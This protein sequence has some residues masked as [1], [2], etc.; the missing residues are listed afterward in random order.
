[1]ERKGGQKRREERRGEQRR[2]EGRRIGIS[3]LTAAPT[4]R[5]SSRGCS[6]NRKAG[7]W[8]H[9]FQDFSKRISRPLKC[10]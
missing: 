2:R 9:M 3:D 5:L 1:M 8:N 4:E 10:L 6:Q 7:G